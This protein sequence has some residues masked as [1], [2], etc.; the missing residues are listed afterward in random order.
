M[1][2]LRL[3][4]LNKEVM[5]A[6]LTMA[7]DNLLAIALVPG[8]LA[9]AAAALALERAALW[10]LRREQAAD[11]AA[12]KKGGLGDDAA[13]AAARQAARERRARRHEAV[14]TPLVV[15]N[16]AATLLLPCYAVFRLQAHPFPALLLTV[17]ALVL[18]MK[19]C[20]VGGRQRAGGLAT[21]PFARLDTKQCQATLTP[22]THPTSTNKHSNTQKKQLMSFHHNCWHLR[23]LR[24]KYG[25]GARA[26]GE[27]GGADAAGG[28][29]APW[30]ALAYPENLTVGNMLFFLAVPTLVAQVNYPLLPRRRPALVLRWAALFLALGSLELLL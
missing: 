12:D 20:V 23:A 11:A 4:L 13:A 19:V 16:V 28:P 30:A 25:A 2:K 9:F 22:T 10:L 27:R 14:V 17:G 1:Y 6:L 26:F 21:T 18:Q 29:P 3:T 7:G 8:L 15:A 24:R 5:R